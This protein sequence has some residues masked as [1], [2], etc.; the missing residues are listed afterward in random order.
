VKK[1]NSPIKIMDLIEN[2]ITLV[3]KTI[4]LIRLIVGGDAM[5]VAAKRNQNIVMIGEIDIM[6]L[7]R[8]RLRV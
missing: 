7:D 4:S 1:L 2:D 5:F 6:P 3:I 8:Y